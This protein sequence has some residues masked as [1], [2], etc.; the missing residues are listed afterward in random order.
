MGSGNRVG[1][2]LDDTCGAYDKLHS[3]DN[4]LMLQWYPQRVMRLAKG[5]SLLE[6]G[7]GHGYSSVQY[8]KRFKRYRVIDGSS[9]IIKRFRRKFD[10]RSMDIVHAYFERY[11][12]IEKFDNISM[13]FVL[14]HVGDPRLILKRYKKYL[15]PGGSVF[16]AVPNGESLHRRFGREAGL[17]GS[18]TITSSADRA[19]GHKRVFTLSTIE[20]LVRA[21]GYRVRSIEGIFLKPVSTQQLTDLDLSADILQAML[22]V[23]VHYPELSNGILLHAKAAS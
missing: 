7:I 13:G 17:L 6:L 14:E 11:E 20:R 10:V 19:Q 18:Y 3:L 15:K 21:A 12:S 23:G 8:A 2:E 22:K 5:D 4:R 1:V 16:I 9:E